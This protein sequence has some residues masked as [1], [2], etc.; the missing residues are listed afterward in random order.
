M[1]HK[2]GAHIGGVRTAEDL[3][4]RCYCDE[5]AGCWHFRMASGKKPTKN[6]QVWLYGGKTMT[7]QRAMWELAR[8]P[9]KDGYVVSRACDSGDCIN[10]KHLRCRTRAQ[11]VADH[12]KRGKFKV[13][14]KQRAARNTAAKRSALTP[15]LRLWLLESPQTGVDAAHALGISQ[16]RANEIRAQTRKRHAKAAPS[17]FALGEAMNGPQYWRAA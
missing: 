10:P 17:I 2:H 7:V 3:R 8:G 5:E 14:S 13:P 1:T 15:E 6:P 16:A 12:K 9:I 11:T 4:L